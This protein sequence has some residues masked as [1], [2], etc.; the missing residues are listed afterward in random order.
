[1][2]LAG[3]SHPSVKT[4]R[5]RRCSRPGPHVGFP[6][7]V[8]AERPRLLSCVVGRQVIRLN[9]VPGQTR[10]GC[11]DIAVSELLIYLVVALILGLAYVVFRL[12]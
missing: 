10:K 8:V 9:D 3:R 5:T 7:Y 12:S 11:R 1:M 2:E 6:R 4:R